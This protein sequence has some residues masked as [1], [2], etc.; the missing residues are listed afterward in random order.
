MERTCKNI[1][2]TENLI[3]GFTQEIENSTEITNKALQSSIE[4][5]KKE[6]Q[7]QS[8]ETK[9]HLKKPFHQKQSLN[10]QQSFSGFHW[11]REAFGGTGGEAIKSV[12]RI[13]KALITVNAIKDSAEVAVLSFRKL[14]TVL[15]N[16]SLAL[17]KKVVNQ[18]LY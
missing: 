5:Q 7:T 18:H 6:L 1:N 16:W 9:K 10:F 17:E 13:Q 8:E 12:E 14:N 15:A 4:T 3:K 11:I 2:E